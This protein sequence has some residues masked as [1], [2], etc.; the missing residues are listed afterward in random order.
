MAEMMLNI[1]AN[2]NDAVQGLGF[3]ADRTKQLQTQIEYLRGK[4]ADTKSEKFYANALGIIAQKQTELNRIQKATGEA[5]N[6]TSV[7]SAKATQSLT[8]LSRIAQDAP[9]GF[10]GI[11]NNI[12]PLIESFGRLKASTGTT[13]GA[14]KALVA[15]LAGPAGIGLAVGVASSLMVAF[16]DR[17]FNLGKGANAANEE[18]KKLGE[19]VANDLV[20]V[21]SLVG[22]AGNLNASYENRKKALQALNEQYGKYLPGLEKEK[23]TLDNLTKAYDLITESILRQAVVKGTQNEIEK[24]VA[25]TAKNIIALRLKEAQAVKESAEAYKEQQKASKPSESNQ[26]KFDK[27][28]AS[29]EKGNRIVKDGAIALQSQKVAQ[30]E[31]IRSVNIYDTLIKKLT[32]DLK[33]QLQPLM[34]LTTEFSDLG[35][36]L[37]ATKIEFTPSILPKR[38]NLLVY[39]ANEI[40]DPIVKRAKDILGQK[41]EFTGE[42]EPLDPEKII[43]EKDFRLRILFLT[44][45][46]D[47]GKKQ[48]NA[49]IEGIQIDALAALGEGI[50][51]ALSGGGLRDVFS[52]FVNTIAGGVVAIGK[53]MIALGIKAAL[54]KDALKSL[55]SNPI[56]LVAAGVGLIAVGS[57]IRGAV[58]QGIEARE[59]GGPVSGNTP[60]LVGERGPE[61]FVP[62]VGGSIIP[63]NRMTSFSG[64][65]S[66]ASSGGGRSIVRGN[67][68]LLAYARTSRSQNRVNA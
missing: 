67:D 41:F 22:L 2:V 20:K 15:G 31:A 1:G 43:A 34:S 30:N 21:T 16:G 8:D 38:R 61:L 53:Q 65:T 5:L 13:G 45:L 42:I 6:K 50:G 44:K 32:A 11:A 10:I 52:G 36:T 63:N 4:L 49:A 68:I 23:I 39:T 66:M 60:Y 26:S 17:L 58:G 37:S 12:N 56:A 29:V 62:S 47:D 14:L 57:A 55:F 51:K 28:V 46:F 9:Y 27:Y 24:I 59:K 35:E 3:V 18:L 54:L 64:R 19:G 25:E 7:N 33:D 40:F 48:I